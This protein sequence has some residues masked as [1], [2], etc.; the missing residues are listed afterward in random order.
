MAKLRPLAPGPVAERRPRPGTPHT[1]PDPRDALLTDQWAPTSQRS[2]SPHVC[3]YLAMGRYA[4]PWIQGWVEREI[5]GGRDN[6][7]DDAL[8]A[9]YGE[10]V[11]A[12]CRAAGFEPAFRCALAKQLPAARAAAKQWAATFVVEHRDPRERRC[13]PHH[14]NLP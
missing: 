1:G 6:V 7:P 11:A 12:V 5:T 9:A 2:P 4:S 8:V 3:F 14:P 10:S 13:V